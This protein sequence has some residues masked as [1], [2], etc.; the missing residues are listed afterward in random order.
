MAIFLR[1]FN[2]FYFA[3]S[4]CNYVLI[5]ILMVEIDSTPSKTPG[6]PKIPKVDNCNLDF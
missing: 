5:S 4:E 6:A 1:K 3:K 2:I